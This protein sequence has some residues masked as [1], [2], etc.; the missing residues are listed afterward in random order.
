MAKRQVLP[1]AD[2]VALQPKPFRRARFKSACDG[3]V[4]ESV[5]AAERSGGGEAD[6]S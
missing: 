5:E 1:Q 6:G 3:T 2:R 4:P